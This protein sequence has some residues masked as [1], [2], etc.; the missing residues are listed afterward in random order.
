MDNNF[1]SHIYWDVLFFMNKQI[2]IVSVVVSVIASV[3]CLF[4]DWRISSGIIIGEIA[5]LI[6]FLLLNNSFKLK[7]DGSMSKG[8]IV[9]FLLR[10]VVI[11]LPLTIA[12]FLPKFFNIFGAFAGVMLF[13]IVMIIYFFKQKGELQ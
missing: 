5:S 6:Y 13:R 4:F 7:E 1:A 9:S 11:A 2:Y 10:I 8:G 3:I 12:F